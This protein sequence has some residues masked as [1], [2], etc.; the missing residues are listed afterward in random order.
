MLELRYLCMYLQVGR[1]GL[2]TNLSHLYGIP[3]HGHMSYTKR[4]GGDTEYS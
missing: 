3:S 1:K 2:G 4:K